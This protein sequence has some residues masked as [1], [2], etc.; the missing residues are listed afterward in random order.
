MV[1]CPE[2]QIRDPDTKEC[3]DKKPPGRPRKP[4]C[5]EGQ[6]RDPDTKE[7][8]DKK[9]PGR[10][11]KPPCP[12]GQIRDPTTKECREKLRTR[13]RQV[14]PIKAYHVPCGRVMTLKQHT[15]TCWFNALLMGL[16]YSQGM[17]AVMMETMST[18]QAPANSPLNRFYAT[19]KDIILR[20]F[21][22]KNYDWTEKR[23][24]E[25]EI[26][27][28]AFAIIKPEHILS[29]LNKINKEAFINRG[30]S[31]KQNGGWGH[32]YLFNVMQ[33]LNVTKAAYID[34]IEEDGTF[35]KSTLY[36]STFTKA[37]AKSQRQYF[38][39][40]QPAYRD[41]VMDPDPDVLVIRV[42]PRKFLLNLQKPLTFPMDKPNQQTY[43]YN[44]NEYLVDSLYLE[45]F[46]DAICKMAHAIAG[47]TCGNNRYMYNG[48]S[49]DTL[50]RGLQHSGYKHAYPCQLIPF[51]WT[52]DYDFCIN[53]TLCWMP[54]VSGPSHTSVC[55]N[56]QKGSRYILAVKRPIQERGFAYDS[57]LA[58]AAVRR[59]CGKTK[60]FN[61]ATQA[62]EDISTS[63]YKRLDHDT[64]LSP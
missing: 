1:R 29:M 52:D 8:R 33:V 51:D 28:K 37:D 50:D 48:W 41:A 4:P 46:N 34:V 43:R 54:K 18:W 7:C 14:V 42:K 55:F 60:A 47:I 49:K 24:D 10:Q 22:H 64:L 32:G 19:V 56:P 35:Y 23:L 39:V 27:A 3:R 62:C 25:L 57:Q 61:P 53:T 16:F 21:V 38:A 31:Q 40:D 13:K 26:D 45:N 44:N 58:S 5:P 20:K 15:G 59:M 36:G 11:R 17:R 30:I 63:Y 9:P 6:I 2:G 12:E